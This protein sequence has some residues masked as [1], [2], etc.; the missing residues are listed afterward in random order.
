MM[1]WVEINKPTL[2]AQYY[3][4]T[5]NC[6]I[7]FLLQLH[8]TNTSI[9]TEIAA[10]IPPTDKPP[11]AKPPV[12]QPE[13]PL[14]PLKLEVNNL[15]MFM[16]KTNI[17]TVMAPL[18][19]VFTLSLSNGVVPP[20]LKIAKVVP[21][22][23]SGNILNMKNFR[24]ISLLSDFFKILEKIVYNHLIPYLENNSVLSQFQFGFGSFHSTIHP[25]TLLL[26]TLS[27][28]LNLKKHSR[29]IF[30]DLKSV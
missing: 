3:A 17:N 29:D 18:R 11:G 19:H 2:L 24:P 1:P 26:N 25:M 6:Q 9:A 14:L 23:K 15:S 5:V 4:T 21:I 28:S 12:S 13:S 22:F 20:K 16:L 30:C 7:L 27:N 8:L 10:E